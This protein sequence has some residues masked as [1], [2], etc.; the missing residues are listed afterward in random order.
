M[1]DN[2]E[3][4]FQVLINGERQYSI[5]PTSHDL[6]EGWTPVGVSG[7]KAECLAYIDENWTDM[8]PISLQ[9]AMGPAQSH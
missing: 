6:P 3:R 2:E 7:L 5:W 8:R 9:Q 4:D 1:F